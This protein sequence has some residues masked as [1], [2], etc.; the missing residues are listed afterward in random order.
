MELEA[1]QAPARVWLR[2]PLAAADSA[3]HQVVTRE[4]VPAREVLAA[5]REL[6]VL[7]EVYSC[8]DAASRPSSFRSPEHAGS[9][10]GAPSRNR[11]AVAIRTHHPQNAEELSLGGR[12]GFRCQRIGRR[13]REV[14]VAQRWAAGRCPSTSRI[15]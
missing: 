2:A 3:D 15:A 13:R 9:F 6:P 10:A 7:H 11:F 4:S 8:R 1:V 14:G 12:C 5:L